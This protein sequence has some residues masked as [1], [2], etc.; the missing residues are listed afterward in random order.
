A[1]C[2]AVLGIEEGILGGGA[3]GDGG[4]GAATSSGGHDGGGGMGTGAGGGLGGGGAASTTCPPWAP[5]EPCDPSLMDDADN[6]CH[7]GRSCQGG[8]CMDGQCTPVLLDGDAATDTRGID[9]TG[10][11]VYW[12]TGSNQL[13]KSRKTDA[14]LYLEVA[15]DSNYTPSLAT[16][17]THA[18][19]TEWQAGNVMRAPLDGSGPE[20]LVGSVNATPNWGRIDV[21]PTHVVWATRNTDV[22]VWA[23][24]IAPITG[25]VF[26]VASHS[27]LGLSLQTVSAPLGVVVD[28]THLYFSDESDGVILRR[29]LSS[30]AGEDD[31]MADVVASNQSGAGDLAVDETHVYWVTGSEIHRR[32][33]DGSGGVEVLAASQDDPNALVVDDHYVTWVNH[34]TATTGTV[35]RT[36]KDGGP[37]EVLAENQ[38]APWEI[39][40]DCTTIYWTNH[41]DFMTGEVWKVAK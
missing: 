3:G 17:A 31:V 5:D 35:H 33:K 14:S 38:K 23:A 34:A 24:P 41:N 4:S 10:D 8:T 21:S 15:F 36:K 13:I 19:W 6:C 20:E 28:A 7:L 18:Y 27:T 25:E 12:S 39:A 11:R 2:N 1:A 30:I 22:G 16:D 37:L 29:S 32:L 26:A 40:Q 9:V